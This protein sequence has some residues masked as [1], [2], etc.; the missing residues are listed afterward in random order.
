M[1]WYSFRDSFVAEYTSCLCGRPALADVQAIVKLAFNILARLQPVHM[2]CPPEHP[3][4]CRG[5]S[6]PTTVR[7]DLPPFDGQL[8]L[9][10][11]G[12]LYG[13][14]GYPELKRTAIAENR[15]VHQVDFRDIQCHPERIS[16]VGIS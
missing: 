14:D 13:L 8:L 16:E 6:W 5:A 9:Y 11:R 3:S 1:S 10:A 2:K 12:A 15:F 7:H 4:V